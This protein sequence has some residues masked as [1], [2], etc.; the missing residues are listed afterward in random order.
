[1]AFGTG[2]HG[3]TKGC[4]KSIEWLNDHGFVAK[5][6]ADIGCGTSLLA[7]A[8]TRVWNARIVAS[9]VDDT[10]V[11]VANVNVRTNGLRKKVICVRSAGFGHVVHEQNAPYDLI[12][13][14]ILKNVLISLASDVK[15]FHSVNGYVVLSGMLKDQA[16]HVLSS[17]ATL[18]YVLVHRFDISEWTT[19]ILFNQC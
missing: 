15:Q 6:I 1:M 5:S 14:N 17:Y 16:D 11:E 9:D 2:Q 18:G 7:I 10:A 19:L 4:L 13:V 8:S 12:F 3:S